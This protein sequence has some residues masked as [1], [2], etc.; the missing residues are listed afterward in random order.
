LEHFEFVSTFKQSEPDLSE[1]ER[2]F[3]ALWSYL[4]GDW[5]FYEPCESGHVASSFTNFEAHG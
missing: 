5:V 1:E 3:G 2:F 4:I